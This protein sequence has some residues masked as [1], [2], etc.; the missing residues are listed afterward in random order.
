MPV[1]DIVCLNV[2]ND[3]QDR[4]NVDVM[5]RSIKNGGEDTERIKKKKK[6]SGRNK[7][8]KRQK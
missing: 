6:K 3:L 2:E 1:E 7:H 4:G 8:I 5:M